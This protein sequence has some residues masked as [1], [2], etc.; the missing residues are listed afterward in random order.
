MEHID[1]TGAYPRIV[2]DQTSS[3]E[4][5]AELPSRRRI[6]RDVELIGVTGLMMAAL[7]TIMQAIQTV[8]AFLQRLG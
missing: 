7:Q 3:D 2:S 8:L 6:W 1:L 4:P 5:P